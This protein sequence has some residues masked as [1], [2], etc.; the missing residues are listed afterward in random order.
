MA[1]A[2]ARRY[3]GYPFVTIALTLVMA[4]AL[5]AWHAKV[6]QNDFVDYQRR[7]T[8]QSVDGVAAEITSFITDLKTSVA[9]FV[10]QGSGG[11]SCLE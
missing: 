6:R 7:L 3:Q 5:V 8:K 2:G 1:R 4:G 9:A 11:R 10:Q